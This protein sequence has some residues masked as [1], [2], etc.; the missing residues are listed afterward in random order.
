MTSSTEIEELVVELVDEIVEEIMEDIGNGMEWYA[1]E[2]K[3]FDI[4]DREKIAKYL[5]GGINQV[6][7]EYLQRMEDT[8][9]E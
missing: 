7:K 4:Q 6:L 9:D 3:T 1:G 2:L 5:I 8:S